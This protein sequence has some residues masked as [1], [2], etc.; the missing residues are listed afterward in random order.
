MTQLKYRAIDGSRNNLRNPHMGCSYTSF[1]RLHK[2]SYDDKIHSV[3]RS[4]RGYNLPSPRNIV[5]KLFLNDKVNL[6]KFQGRKMIPNNLALMLGKYIANDVG[7]KQ[8]VQYVNG[9][10]G[11]IPKANDCSTSE[12]LQMASD[13]A[14]T[15]T[16]F[17]FHRH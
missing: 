17:S 16:N 5:R 11:E 9:G 14:P 8:S 2:A 15:T 4:V 13:V 3:R 7:C 6:N 12:L 10:E 1:G